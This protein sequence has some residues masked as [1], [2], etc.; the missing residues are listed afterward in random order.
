MT[1]HW[2]WRAGKCHRGHDVTDPANVYTRPGSRWRTC[3]V[4]LREYRRAYDLAHRAAPKPRK[5]RVLAERTCE[6]CGTSYGPRYRES[7]SNFE[8]RR[9]CSM[10]CRREASAAVDPN[11]SGPL[12]DAELARLRALVGVA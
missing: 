6:H 9:F 3:A 12:A 2:H 4:C 7:R 10:A 1:D 11:R 5:R 8:M